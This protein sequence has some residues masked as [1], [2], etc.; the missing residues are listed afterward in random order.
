[1]SQ[2]RS[3]K[4]RALVPLAVAGTAQ[5]QCEDQDHT[6]VC[7]WS[8]ISKRDEWQ[9]HAFL[10]PGPIRA[11]HAQ[12]WLQ[13]GGDPEGSMERVCPGSALPAH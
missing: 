3:N 10:S 1:M 4:P 5:T 8:E 9:A 12:H 11:M 7:D 13:R 6:W 2:E